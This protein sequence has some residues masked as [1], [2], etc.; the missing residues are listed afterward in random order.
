VT[1][2]R[3]TLERSGAFRRRRFV[4][5]HRRRSRTRMLLRPF[6]MAV[7][8]VGLPVAVALWVYSSPRFLLREVQI[9]S[10]RHI[11]TAEVDAALASLRGRH[12]LGL[13]L[14]DVENLLV[15]NPWV[16]RVA[17]RKELPDRLV[18]EIEERLPVALLRQEG[19]LVYVDSQGFVIGAYGLDGPV[20]L[21]LLSVAPGAKLEVAATL[22]LAAELQR[23]APATMQDLSEIEVLGLGDYRIHTAGLDFPVLI[24]STGLERQIAKLA[25]LLPEMN[26][27]FDAIEAVDLRFARQIVIQPAGDPRSQEG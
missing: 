5:P 22:E 20:D 24:S 7:G 27:R 8:L 6:L 17:V 4:V 16:E 19:E 26:Q 10:T 15:A 1:T 11:S 21:L 14:A 13:S 25:A 3:L 9:G 12:L 23:L 2:Q 18:V